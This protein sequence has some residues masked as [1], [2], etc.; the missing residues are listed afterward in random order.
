MVIEETIYGRMASWAGLAALV[1]DRIYPVKLPQKVT[2]PAVAYRRAATAREV[3]DGA[4]PGIARVK[5]EVCACAGTWLEARQVAQQ[6]RLALERWWDDANGVQDS[7]IIDEYE[8]Y[9]FE[10]QAFLRVVLAEV[11]HNEEV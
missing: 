7:Y 10:A 3:L 8:D 9:D 2:L 5:F 1:R 6:V 4:D 11:V